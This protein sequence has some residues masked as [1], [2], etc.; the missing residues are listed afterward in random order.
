MNTNSLAIGSSNLLSGNFAQGFQHDRVRAMIKDSVERGGD[1][2]K[3]EMVRDGSGLTLET[4][5]HP[6]TSKRGSGFN[7]VGL[8]LNGY[9]HEFDRYSRVTKQLENMPLDQ[10]QERLRTGAYFF[11]EV[12]GEME[13]V[14]FQYD[15]DHAFIHTDDQIK[16]LMDH[17]GVSPIDSLSRR[18]KHLHG[19]TQL[20]THYL[21]APFSAEDM[22]VDVLNRVIAGGEFQSVIRYVWSPFMKNIVSNY[23]LVRLICA[24]GM[25]GT[26]NFMNRKVPLLNMWQENMSIANK[27]TQARIQ[28]MATKRFDSMAKE[29]ASLST[30]LQLAAHAEKRL[31]QTVTCFVV[32]MMWWILV[33]LMCC[34]VYTRTPFSRMQT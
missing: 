32:C 4:I 22:T 12:G 1:K 33:K 5:K 13:L 6:A 19:N 2:V 17:I 28:N 31:N 8:H 30:L 14:D 3:F 7:T 24:N 21:G 26:S 15:A 10:L 25:I 18:N 16:G 23:E 20:T 9:F 29:S 11:I 34:T 27:Q